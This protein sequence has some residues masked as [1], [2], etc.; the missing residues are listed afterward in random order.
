[1]EEQ[2]AEVFY[3]VG[4][5][6]TAEARAAAAARLRTAFGRSVVTRE[7]DDANLAA[8]L[9]ASSA[10]PILFDPVTISFPDGSK[11][12]IDGGVAD[13]APLDVARAFSSN[14]V[15][16]IFVDPARAKPRRFASAAAVG[17]VAFGIAQSR[18]F[19]ASLR[20]A[21]LETRG[22][23]LF[24]RGATTPEQR[25]FLDSALDADL[26]VIRPES[27]LPVE[28]ADFDDADGIAKTYE[29]GRQ[30]GLYG[31]RAYDPSDGAAA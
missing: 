13:S 17:T 18:I 3:R 27:E 30:A 25:A 21:Y 2:R 8:A 26:F 12:Y 10:I 31:F 29:L 28:S 1:L 11:T 7:I 5:A 20:V 19:E 4:V 9:A 23:R 14:R 15:Q 6:L 16:V 22:K 24:A